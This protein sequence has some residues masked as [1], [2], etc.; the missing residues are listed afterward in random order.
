MSTVR[1]DFV[2]TFSGLHVRPLALDPGP[3]DIMDIAHALSHQ[4][5]F[6]GHT[7]S[8]Y[9]VAEHSVRVAEL[10]PMCDRL[11]ALLHDAAEAYLG[12]IVSPLKRRLRVY[13]LEGTDWATVEATDIHLAELRLRVHIC[14]QLGLPADMPPA[15]E[16][17]D[18]V[19]LATEMRDLMGAPPEMYDIA[20]SPLSNAIVPWQ[21][22]QAKERFLQT[23]QSARSW[24]HLNGEVKAATASGV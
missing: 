21:P 24:R 11:A 9:S 2:R 6:N 3:I 19:L 10:V 7:R 17:A 14:H 22:A 16:H 1:E 5:R 8:F 15:V 23:F 4:C 13:R 18:L 20:A 12:D